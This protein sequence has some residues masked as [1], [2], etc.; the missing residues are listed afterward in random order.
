MLYTKLQEEI[1]SACSCATRRLRIEDERRASGGQT[2]F[3]TASAILTWVCFVGR[4][5]VHV[6]FTFS[7]TRIGHILCVMQR[8]QVIGRD[9][10][11]RHDFLHFV[12]DLYIYIFTVDIGH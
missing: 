12:S 9:G 11:K 7:D 10:N 6:C 8:S 4:T 3:V 2:Y 1:T 5:E